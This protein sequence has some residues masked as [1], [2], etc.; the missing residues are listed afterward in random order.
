MSV[1]QMSVSQMSMEQM[2]IG[3]IIFCKFFKGIKHK[4][5]QI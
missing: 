5:H 1:D 4:V 2:S 3:Q